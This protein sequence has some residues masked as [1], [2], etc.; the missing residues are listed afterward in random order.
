M[1]ITMADLPQHTP[2]EQRGDALDKYRT[3][4]LWMILPLVL[5]QAGIFIDYWREL[6]RTIGRFTFTT[7]RP[8]FAICT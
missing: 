7:G 1:A 6:T 4:Y 2:S 5:M 8:R 3:L